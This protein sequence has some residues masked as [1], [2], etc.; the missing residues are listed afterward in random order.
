MRFTI[1]SLNKSSERI[2]NHLLLDENIEIISED[3]YLVELPL[4]DFLLRKYN[5]Q[6]YM[7]DKRYRFIKCILCEKTIR[8]KDKSRHQETKTHKHKIKLSIE[9]N[10]NLIDKD[11]YIET[12]ENIN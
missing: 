12:E 7:N 1:E 11:I 8:L 2:L 3:M 5:K 9:A 4:V 6:E 10:E